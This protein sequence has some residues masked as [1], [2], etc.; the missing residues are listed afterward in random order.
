MKVMKIMKKRITREDGAMNSAEENND[1]M[2]DISSVTVNNTFGPL[3]D[4]E[5]DVTAMSANTD[6]STT[7]QMKLDADIVKI[8][9]IL[10]GVKRNARII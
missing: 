9:F 5:I 4:S 1:E 8:Y 2:A 10:F 3:D 7:I 6:N